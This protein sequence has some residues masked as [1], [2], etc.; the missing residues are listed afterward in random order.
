MG[1]IANCKLTA[2]NF[3]YIF[4]FLTVLDCTDQVSQFII[5][6]NQYEFTNIVVVFLPQEVDPNL[7]SFRERTTL[8]SSSSSSLKVN[9]GLL[10]GV[11]GNEKSLKVA[12]AQGAQPATENSLCDSNWLLLF[13][14]RTFTS[15]LRVCIT[16]SKEPGHLYL[17]PPQKKKNTWWITCF[18]EKPR[19]LLRKLIIKS[20]TQATPPFWNSHSREEI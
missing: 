16:G 9:C 8:F 2:L 13:F 6:G 11:V 10:N 3:G 17:R 14:F 20:R 15:A 4:D 1:Q 5:P 18:G 7:L 19:P 12:I